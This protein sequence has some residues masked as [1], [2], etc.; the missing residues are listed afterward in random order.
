MH[1]SFR[2]LRGPSVRRFMVWGFQ[3]G[4]FP[5]LRAVIFFP[6]LVMPG[7]RLTGRFLSRPKHNRPE[8]L[9]YIKGYLPFITRSTSFFIMDFEGNAPFW[10]KSL[11]VL[12]KLGLFLNA[13]KNQWNSAFL[14]KK[15]VSIRIGKFPTL[16]ETYK[17]FYT[18]PELRKTRMA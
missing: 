11:L 4:R 10:E 13:P 16:L 15:H 8:F 18:E 5:S 12:S 2:P 1:F 17:T 3:I 14:H 6:S 7:L 9:G